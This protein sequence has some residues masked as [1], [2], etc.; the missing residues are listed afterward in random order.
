MNVLVAALARVPLIPLST[1]INLSQWLPCLGHVCVLALTSL[2]IHLLV[3]LG[4]LSFV[5]TIILRLL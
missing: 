1:A 4:H 5:V 2:M 3:T